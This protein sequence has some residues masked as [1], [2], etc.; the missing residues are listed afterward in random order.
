MKWVDIFVIAIFVY[1]VLRIIIIINKPDGHDKA[2]APYYWFIGLCLLCASWATIRIIF[3]SVKMEMKINGGVTEE[4]NKDFYDKN[5]DT[6]SI[7]V[8]PKKKN[9]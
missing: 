3:P 9:R 6:I 8:K 5:S 4:I 1:S 2:I 7:R